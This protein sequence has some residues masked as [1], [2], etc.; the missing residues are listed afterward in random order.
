MIGLRKSA[1]IA[2]R[3]R[4]LALNMHRM[5]VSRLHLI[6]RTLRYA[7]DAAAF[8][9]L[10]A[11]ARHFRYSL[12][13]NEQHGCSL[14]MNHKRVLAA[15]TMAAALA[16]AGI[17]PSAHAGQVGFYIGGQYGQSRKN[18]TSRISTSTRQQNYDLF[19][20]RR[21]FWHVVIGRQR[22]G[23]TASSPATASRRTWRW[24]AA[25]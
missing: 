21:R 6:C 18:P 19:G 9:G 23:L 25:I 4:E 24:R 20:V 11:V 16:G 7:G 14:G 15:A 17:A 1:A 13:P 10:A 22:L 12:L 3:G 8:P 5:P 2:R